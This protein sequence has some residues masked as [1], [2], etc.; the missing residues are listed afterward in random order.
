M[1]ISF[2]LNLVK[3]SLQSELNHFFQA[4]EDRSIPI[5]KVTASAFCRARKKFTEAVFIALNHQSLQT[6][7]EEA[8]IQTWYGHRIL[9]V[10]GSKYYLPDTPQIHAVF[11]GQSNQHK[12][13][14]MA[15][16]SCLYDVFQGL[17]LDAQLAPCRSS[18]RELAYQHLDK[19][20]PGDVLLYDRGYSAF[21]LLAAHVEQQRDFCMRVKRSFNNTTKA[22]V[23]SG[24]KQLITTLTPSDKTR[25]TCRKRGLSEQPIKVRLLRVKTSQG[26]YI[27]MT[28]LMDKKQ[29]PLRAFKALYHLRWQIE[30][31]YK[32][33]KSWIEIENF[34]GK[35]V[36]S[37][38]QDFHARILSLNLTA[39]T[40]FCA[41]GAIKQTVA[42]RYYDYKI[43]F[44]QALSSMKGTLIRLLTG[45]MNEIDWYRWLKDIA[46]CL[47]PLRPDRSFQRKE[48]RIA[49]RRFHENY[50]RAL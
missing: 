49:K 20:K 23:A 30:E 26:S 24:K 27:L 29:Y 18:E 8:K 2:C 32:K 42:Q 4:M 38:R 22:F 46:R 39:M 31:G 21:W 5:M 1:L 33:Q 34:T 19:S 12:E 35:S 3:G 11:G 41:Q 10:D 37:V 36:L 48:T 13:A 9:A 28:S 15:L 47:T 7:Y 25:A 45:R 14:P 43:N 40:I 17:V 16:G 6:F 44:A 50:K